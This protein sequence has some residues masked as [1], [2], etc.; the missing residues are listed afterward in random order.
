MTL[1][2]EDRIILKSDWLVSELKQTAVDR[3]DKAIDGA[4]DAPSILSQSE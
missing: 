4:I 2:T 1:E 3:T